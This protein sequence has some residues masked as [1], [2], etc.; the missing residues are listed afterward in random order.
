MPRAWGGVASGRHQPAEVHEPFQKHFGPH[1]ESSPG[2]EYGVRPTHARGCALADSQDQRPLSNLAASRLVGSLAWTIDV[3]CAELGT[4]NA[5]MPSRRTEL[6]YNISSGGASAP[7][8]A[9]SP[10]PH[11]SGGASAPPGAASPP[12]SRFLRRICLKVFPRRAA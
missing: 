5:E 10:P 6:G 8:G 3:V 7:P 1:V 12:T 11:N 9:A 2:P 4:P